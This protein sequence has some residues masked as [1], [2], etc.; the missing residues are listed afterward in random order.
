MTIIH[1]RDSPFVGGPEKQI[2]GQCARLDRSLFDPLIVSFTVSEPNPFMRAASE[3]GIQTAS[4]PDG[5]ITFSSAV[6]GLRAMLRE[7]SNCIVI[8]SGFKADLTAWLACRAESVPWVAWFHGYTAVTPQVRAYE[9]LD[10][11]AIRRARAVIAVC[12]TAARKLRGL[13]LRNVIS[14]PNAIDVDIIS[15]HG[16]RQSARRELGIGDD[17]LVVGTAARFSA[18]KGLEYFIDAAP[19][20]FERHPDAR[21][22]LI[23]DGPLRCELERRSQK[24]QVS[25]R[26]LFTGFRDDVTWL[27]KSMD[28]FVLPSLMENLPVALLEAMACGA[29]VVATGVGGVK[30]VI[31]PAGVQPIVPRSSDAIAHAINEYLDSPQL[32]ARRS[33]ALLARAREFS[34]D[35][36]IEMMLQAINTQ[37]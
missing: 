3:L 17:E 22:V 1:L 4:V 36:Q 27:L 13:G 29:S 2:L 34:F 14:V 31:E 20:V 5:K 16:T 11:Y 18:E 8:S 24:L 6:K 19:W 30:E 9:A 15:S 33:E 26:V 35:R 25:G 12:E 23:G 37:P 10:T 32:R 21:F 28:V 7:N